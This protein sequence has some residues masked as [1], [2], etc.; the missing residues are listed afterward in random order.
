MSWS[1]DLIPLPKNATYVPTSAPS[2]EPFP[3]GIVLGL[4]LG[5][6]IPLI[7]ACCML[8]YLVLRG[9]STVTMEVRESKPQ[10]DRSFEIESSVRQPYDKS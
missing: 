9:Q 6:G 4:V 8:L 5:L 7:C 2:S 1:I 10:G 3:L